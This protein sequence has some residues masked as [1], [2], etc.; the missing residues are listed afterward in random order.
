MN[1]EYT[2]VDSLNIGLSLS[3]GGYRASGFHLG[4]LT[5]LHKIGL[6]PQVT[7][8]STVSGGTFTGAKYAL[9]LVEGQDFKQFYKEYCSFLQDPD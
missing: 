3:G 5:Y 7:M 4:L 8:I 1:Q 2:P 6:L 9:S